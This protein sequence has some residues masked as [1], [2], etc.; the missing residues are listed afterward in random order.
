MTRSGVKL[1]PAEIACEVPE[2]QGP[3]DVST[4][5]GLPGDCRAE[6]RRPQ[7]GENQV[8]DKKDR[9]RRQEFSVQ[10][11][12]GKPILDH[13]SPGNQAGDAT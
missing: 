1:C 3:G 6:Q 5:M 12:D 7:E 10:K 11:P 4:N 8:A 13:Q 9:A 2:Q